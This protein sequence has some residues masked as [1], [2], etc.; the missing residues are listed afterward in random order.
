MFSKVVT[1]P[2]CQPLMSSLNEASS[3]TQSSHSQS[4]SSIQLWRTQN[5]HD[6][7]VIWC[8]SHLLMGPYVEIALALFEPHK[9]TAVLSSAL[10]VKG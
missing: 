7:S 1:A 6:M 10:E 8:V 2:V 4:S 9:A 5:S 3:S